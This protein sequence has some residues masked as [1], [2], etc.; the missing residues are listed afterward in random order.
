MELE[1][2]ANVLRKLNDNDEIVNLKNENVILKK[3]ITKVKNDLFLAEI[4]NGVKQYKLQGNIE[5]KNND[6]DSVFCNEEE[7]Y[8]SNNKTNK[9]NKNETKPSENKKLNI[10]ISESTEISNFSSHL[11]MRVGII[12]SAEKHPDA[13]S[14]YVEKIDLGETEPR[15]IISGLVAHVTINQVLM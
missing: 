1:S 8:D 5:N 15:T 14:L 9:I 6:G 10:E 11:D 3:E 7:L 13:D 4:W 2:L 12:K